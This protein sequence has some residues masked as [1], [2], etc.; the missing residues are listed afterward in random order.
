MTE[1]ARLKAIPVSIA[2]PQIR[3]LIEQQ[4]IRYIDR[5]SAKKVFYFLRRNDRLSSS[6]EKLRL[7]VFIAKQAAAQFCLISQSL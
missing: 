2:R 5:C 6:V 7:G 4:F 1:F 3:H